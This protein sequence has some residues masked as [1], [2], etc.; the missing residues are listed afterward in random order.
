MLYSVG[1]AMMMACIKLRNFM[2]Y[3]PGYAPWLI[4]MTVNDVIS[5]PM[6][7]LCPGLRFALLFSDNR[8]NM[9]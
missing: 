9:E 3:G 2:Q 8:G 5:S 6:S 7:V 4:C 1:A